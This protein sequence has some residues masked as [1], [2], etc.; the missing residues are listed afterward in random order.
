M[1]EDFYDVLGYRVR[2]RSTSEEFAARARQLLRSF[3]WTSSDEPPVDVTL[4]ALVAP[5]PKNANIRPFHFAYR[6]Y[7]YSGKAFT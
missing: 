7:G 3:P 5:P 6:D 4:S 1:S 2:L